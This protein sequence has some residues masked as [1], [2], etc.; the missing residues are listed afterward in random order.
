MQYT[1]YGIH[2]WVVSK[3]ISYIHSD[4]HIR[5]K[6]LRNVHSAYKLVLFIYLA[7]QAWDLADRE[8]MRCVDCCP[9]TREVRYQKRSNDGNQHHNHFEAQHDETDEN[10]ESVIWVCRKRELIKLEQKLIP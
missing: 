7:I 3:R 9:T 6:T 4:T 1:V 2:E 8:A 10:K 5:I